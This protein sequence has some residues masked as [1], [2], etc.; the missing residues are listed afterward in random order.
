MSWVACSTWPR[1]GLIAQMCMQREQAERAH[2]AAKVLAAQHE[3]ALLQAK[4]R[5]H[6]ATPGSLPTLPS[7]QVGSWRALPWES[8]S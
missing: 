5:Q 4:L 3:A 1:E 7:P 6:A 8:C 2:A